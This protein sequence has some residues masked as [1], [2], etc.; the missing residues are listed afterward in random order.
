MSTHGCHPSA[1]RSIMKRQTL[2]AALGGTVTARGLTRTCLF[3]KPHKMKG[4]AYTHV[5]T[6][7]VGYVAP[8]TSNRTYGR[9]RSYITFG[10]RQS[11][12]V[13]RLSTTSGGSISSVHRLIRRIHVPPRV[14]G[15]GICVVSRMRVL[16][17]STFGTFLGALRRPPHRTVFVLTAARGRGV[18]PAVLSHYRVCSFGHVDIRSAI[19]RLSCITSGRKVSTRPRTLGIVTVGTSK[20]VHSTLSVFSRI[21]DFAKKGVACGD[22]VSGLGMLSCRC[23]FHLA[24]YFLTGGIDSTLL[25]FG[26][27]LGGKFSKDRFVAKLSSRF[28]SLLMNGSPMALPLLRIKTDVHRHCRRR[29]R[30][31]PLPF[32]CGTVGLYGRYSLGCHVDGGGHLLIRLA[33]VRITRLAAR[34]SSIDNKHD[35]GRAVGPIFS[36]PTTTRPSRMTST[37][38]MRRTPIRSSPTSIATGI[39]PGERPRVTAATEPMSP[40]TAGAASSTPLPNTKVPSITGRRQG[41]PI[42]GVSDLNMSV[43]GPRHSRT[44]RG[45]AMTRIPEIRRP[46]RSSGFGRQSLGCC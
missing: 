37:S 23:C 35:P 5:F 44:T 31:Y 21:I 20:N 7:A 15:C 43:G 29:T 2:A 30:G 13:R 9:Y 38:S 4:A 25:L 17:T 32:L 42:V 39:A 19:G 40:S 16:S 41:I 36:R 33:L 18:L 8:A 22:I 46:R 45:T 12:G 24:S 3:Y 26:S 11:C 34:K 28:H 14:N 10:R 1:F 27:I 6:G